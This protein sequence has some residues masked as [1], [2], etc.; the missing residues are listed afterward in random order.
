MV[1]PEALYAALRQTGA[2]AWFDLGRTTVLLALE[3]HGDAA[4]TLAEGAAVWEARARGSTKGTSIASAGPAGGGVHPSSAV[5]GG[6]PDVGAPDVDR[7]VNERVV[8]ASPRPLAQRVVGG[9]FGWFSYEAGAWCLPTP[10]PRTALPLPAAWLARATSAAV[11]ASGRWDL[12]TRAEFLQIGPNASQVG[13]NASGPDTVAAVPRTGDRLFEAWHHAVRHGAPA[14][15][16]AHGRVVEAT[17][18]ATYVAGV[19]AIQEHLRAGDCYQVNLARRLTVGA[20]GTP[21]DAW[22]RL[23]ALNPARRGALLETRHGA[24]VSNSPELLLHAEGGRALS[25]PIKGTSARSG[26]EQ[27]RRS[28]LESPKERA[29]LRMIVDLVRADLAR[30][31]RPGSIR[32]GARRVG[33]VGHL[34]HAMQRV[35]CD[36]D[37]R[38]DAVD[39]FRALFPAGS[40]T[41]AP[42][43]RAMEVIH[44]LEPVSR[45]VYCGSIGGFFDIDAE[46]RACAGHW[47]VAI[48]TL[49]FPASSNPTSMRS[50]SADEAHLHVGAGI[51]LGSDPEREWAE[52]SLKAERLLQAVT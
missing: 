44:A 24:V 3:D 42:R 49:S 33:A 2:A 18:E 23:H 15:D 1:S 46:A 27:A 37:L 35:S 31:A 25:V 9:T 19:R 45:G 8:A 47:N 38:Y 32:T 13:P 22:R 30:V 52:T 36:L 51:V 5:V 17:P 50:S 40:V 16:A 7:E 26:G 14:L 43:M 34:W 10:A 29:E 11:H 20:P 12:A 39:A 41:G 28:L 4:L 21:F 6:A 48:R